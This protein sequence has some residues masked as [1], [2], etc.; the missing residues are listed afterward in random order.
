MEGNRLLH[1]LHEGYYV[2]WLTFESGT[3]RKKLEVLTF[4]KGGGK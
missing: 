3:S 2:S 1:K 4:E